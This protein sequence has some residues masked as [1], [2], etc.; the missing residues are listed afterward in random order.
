[1]AGVYS[2]DWFQ[3][4]TWDISARSG[5][6]LLEVSMAIT[7]SDS[8]SHQQKAVEGVTCGTRNLA[9]LGGTRPPPW[10]S[11]TDTDA[12]QAVPVYWDYD[13]SAVTGSSPKAVYFTFDS[14][15]EQ[16]V[17][18]NCSTTHAGGSY[19]AADPYHWSFHSF[20]KKSI[21]DSIWRSSA[22]AELPSTAPQKTQPGSQVV[23]LASQYSDGTQID[24]ADEFKG[25]SLWC[26]FVFDNTPVSEL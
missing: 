25:K 9:E 10:S 20:T 15:Y 8:A 18:W 16:L 2:G 4:R 12:V 26:T 7:F 24:G 22:G 3:G 19:T 23:L 5:R 17:F 11:S 21:A 6:R 13:A 14:S 1:M